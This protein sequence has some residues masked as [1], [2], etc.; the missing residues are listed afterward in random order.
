MASA[1]LPLIPWSKTSLLTARAAV[2][3]SIPVQQAAVDLFV[4]GYP[5]LANKLIDSLYEHSHGIEFKT[6]GSGKALMM[7]LDAAWEATGTMPTYIKHPDPDKI[8][9]GHNAGD[10][11]SR[12]HGVRLEKEAKKESGEEVL[13]IKDVA[14]FYS[15]LQENWDNDD[16]AEKD[17]RKWLESRL[18]LHHSPKL[19]ETLKGGAI[20]KVL[21][22]DERVLEAFVDEGCELIKQRFTRGPARPYADKTISELLQ[23]MDESYVAARKANPDAGEHLSVLGMEDPPASFLKPPATE[24]E[25]TALKKRLSSKAFPGNKSGQLMLPDK[26]IPD[27]YEQFLRTS[28]GF[29]VQEGDETGIFCGAE[30]VGDNDVTHLRELEYTLFPYGYTELDG[31]DNID[32]GDFSAFNIGPGGDEGNVVLIPPSSVKSMVEAFEIAYAEASEKHKRLYERA[33]LDL[34]GGIEA[35]RALEWLCVASYHWDP[36]EHIYGSFKAY[37]EHCADYAVKRRRDDKKDAE[38]V[39]KK[40]AEKGESGEDPG[41]KRKRSEEHEERSLSAETLDVKTN[42]EKQSANLRESKSQRT[43]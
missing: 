29:E 23:I 34:Y 26:A 18:D 2:D 43:E 36:D 8:Y 6:W 12:T 5:N 19:W 7:S 1:H 41:E 16:A 15:Y 24:E 22:I 14:G 35:V 13:T 39:R 25:V 37:L 21:G 9:K 10:K 28:N 38:K 42:E 17:L 31:I 32:L 33:A 40:K 11:V 4:L 30:Q 3:S 20:G 27:D